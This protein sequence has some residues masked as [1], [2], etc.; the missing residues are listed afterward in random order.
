[1]NDPSNDPT[2]D[3]FR[4]LPVS[5]RE[6]IERLD[7]AP[8]GSMGNLPDWATTLVCRHSDGT[9]D[10]AGLPGLKRPSDPNSGVIGALEFEGVY[11]EFNHGGTSQA[12]VATKPEP[13]GEW[14]HKRLTDY[15]DTRTG[16]IE[17]ACNR[18]ASLDPEERVRSRDEIE[19]A[20]VEH[21]RVLEDR[22]LIDA[23]VPFVDDLYKAATR[24][25]GSWGQDPFDYLTAS[26][27]TLS[28][29]LVDRGLQIQYLVDNHWDDPVDAIELL[30][31]WFG[32]AG[33]NFIS[34]QDLARQLAMSDG[35]GSDEEVAR[36]APAY[37]AEARHEANEF[38]RECQE[39][40]GHLVVFDNDG[41]D[42]TWRQALKR[43]GDPGVIT[44]FRNAAPQP[45]SKVTAW[46]PKRD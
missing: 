7:P 15:W 21:V 18:L 29:L 10:A 13:A 17:T 9:I 46:L 39:L 1:V 20:V 11:I 23:S 43:R 34:P 8:S 22:H 30:K 42:E 44:I 25:A 6:L 27:G 36:R 33:F 24:W 38:T 35:A 19:R 32:A 5:L 14:M 4:P 3:L 40:G 41:E 26:A 2:E 12:V 28:R 31:V 16:A 37:A 45:A